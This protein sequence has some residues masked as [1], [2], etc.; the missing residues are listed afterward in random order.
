[1]LA[2]EERI[3]T[4][5][6]ERLFGKFAGESHVELV[7]G[8]FRELALEAGSDVEVIFPPEKIQLTIS[9]QP[10]PVRIHTMIFRGTA[11]YEKV[12]DLL[13]MIDVYGFSPVRLESFEVEAESSETVRFAMRL[14]IPFY[15]YHFEIPELDI[16]R[17]GLVEYVRKKAT[18]RRSLVEQLDDLTSAKNI[19]AVSRALAIFD[20]QTRSGAVRLVRAR[21]DGELLLEGVSVGAAARAS[22]LNG[23]EAAGLDVQEASWAPRGVCRSF[24][25]L[26]R[27]RPIERE[28]ELTIENGPFEPD[29]DCNQER[30]TEAVQVELVGA[31]SGEVLLDLELEDV[32]VADIFFVLN[33]L[34]GESFVVG[35]DVEG[36]ADV[37]LK[38][39]T[40]EESLDAIE[41]LGIVARDGPIRLIHS[42]GAADRDLVETQEVVGEAVGF[43]LH[44]VDVQ[45]VLC[46]FQELVGLDI[47]AA[48]GIDPHLSVFVTDQPWD[49]TI[50]SVLEAAG[51]DY[52]IDGSTVYVGY[53]EEGEPQ[54]RE[55]ATDVCENFFGSSTLTDTPMNLRDLE[56]EELQLLGTARAGDGWRA[57][58]YMP[59]R[60]IV[61]VNAG[62]ELFGGRIGS[63]HADGISVESNGSVVEISLPR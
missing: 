52:A 47:L 4:L 10:S 24:S 62:D 59:W 41:D 51:L 25:L 45:G 26:T 28:Q 15:D 20:D 55:R 22:V 18:F 38:G 30:Q 27:L 29:A 42:A 17:L 46:T 35:P 8:K 9:D 21:F 16:S 53:V 6:Y 3:D 1:M 11:R 49:L 57:Y 23:A 40:L 36:R 2:E 19:S 14:Q 7:T 31:G 13:S 44:D 63:V 54:W 60:K 34:T 61:R 50:L 32:E 39:A 37:R 43:F 56:A 5:L 12:E 58:V 48:P 33:D